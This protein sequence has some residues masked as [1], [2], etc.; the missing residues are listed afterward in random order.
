MTFGRSSGVSSNRLCDQQKRL[1]THVPE[2]LTG[3]GERSYPA[4]TGPDG[5]ASVGFLKDVQVAS[6]HRRAPLRRGG[7]WVACIRD[8][9]G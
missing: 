2:A 4:L 1:G 6:P 5:L 9:G 3:H 7:Q 8:R